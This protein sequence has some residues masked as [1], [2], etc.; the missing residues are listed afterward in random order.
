MEG[1]VL[2]TGGAGFIGSHIAARLLELG[3][4]VRVLDNLSTGRPANLDA[5][6][7]AGP[8]RFEFLEGDIRDPA[9]VGR[10]MRDVVEVVH[11]AALPSVERSVHDP[12]TSHEVNADGTLR[13]LEGARAVRARRFL[14]A[15]SSSVYGDQPELPKREEMAPSPRSPYALSKLVAEQYV[16]LYAELYGL[17]TMTLRYFNVFGPRQDP[18]SP[19]AAVIPL[20]LRA[21]LRGESP[22]IYGDGGQTRDFTYISNVV[23]ANLAALAA[24]AAL[25]DVVNIACGARVSLLDLLKALEETTG[26]RAVPRFAPPRAGDVRD[27]QADIRKA[28][29][30][31]GFDPRVT[32][33][34]GLAVTVAAFQ[35]ETLP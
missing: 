19:Y 8:E 1:I 23:D 2:V 16:R 27:S 11:Q 24:P 18:A 7:A 17:P 34:E 28:R 21:I 32:I 31:L 5:A 6:R 14:L 29:T 12:W 10:A 25:G 13:L 9:T 4:R 33:P 30:L 20:F 3:R 35:K 22:T 26:R 15:G